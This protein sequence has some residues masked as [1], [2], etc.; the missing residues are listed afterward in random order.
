MADIFDLFRQISK[1]ESPSS[2]PVSRLIVGLGNPGEEYKN[3]RHNAG[4][5]TVD[6]LAD[7]LGT[8]IDRMKFHALTAE[9]TIGSER[10]LLVKP[11]TYMNNSGQAVAEAASFYKIPP[12]RILVISD[13]ISLAPGRMRVR[14]KGSAG[15]QKGLKSIIEHLGSEDFPRIRMGV[16]AKPHP[17]YDLA[18]WV[19]SNF[20]KS[21]AEALK[22]AIDCAREGIRLIVSDK[23][24]EAVQLCNSHVPTGK[25]PN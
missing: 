13:D 20:S 23:F 15:G 4:F 25:D 3:T 8:H 17:D 18:D 1:K 12:E 24:D 16:G 7:S 10:V 14:R 6:A 21:E 19:L 5:L 11:M 22:S 2:T 9:A